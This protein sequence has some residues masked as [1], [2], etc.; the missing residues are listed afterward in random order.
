[1]FILFT[2]LVAAEQEAEGVGAAGAPQGL[3]LDGSCLVAG[4]ALANGETQEVG[5]IL[6]KCVAGSLEELQD[7][8]REVKTCA[9]R[10]FVPPPPAP[11]PPGG[12]GSTAPASVVE[13]AFF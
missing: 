6:F 1:M 12:T 13:S 8:T 2:G 11:P 9:S 5:K 4:K 3:K 10:S 7:G